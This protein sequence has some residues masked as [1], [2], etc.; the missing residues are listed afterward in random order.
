ME[1]AL[2]K[3]GFSVK[4]IFGGRNW[5]SP[6]GKALD[7]LLFNIELL[8]KQRNGDILYA[9]HIPYILLPILLKRKAYNTIYVHWHGDDLL[10]TTGM[11]RP[12]KKKALSASCGF[13][14]IVPSA[15]FAQKWSELSG[16]PIEEVMI[17]PSG[18]VDTSV[19][20][21]SARSETN[22]LTLGF[23][24][25]L[26]EEKGLIDLEKIIHAKEEL[27]EGSGRK[28]KIRIIDYGKDKERFKRKHSLDYI[29][30]VPPMPK[31]KMVDFYRSIDILLF[32]SQR[33]S[34]S[35]GLV[36][37][38]AM[39]S[40]VPVLGPNRFAVPEYIVPGKSGR[41]YSNDLIG[42]LTALVD[43]MEEL[44]PREIIEERYSLDAVIEM[45]KARFI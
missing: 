34:E 10:K 39:S 35:L 25:G 1:V 22:E 5:T 36:S 19:F 14:H 44:N 8:F 3:A 40:G 17:I 24:S 29:D 6:I 45:Y 20:Y 27:E 16:R 31:E 7:Q 11:W 26:V 12:F 32:F 13:K 33:E 37:L 4:A 41:I 30:Y 23:A 43:E 18:G 42:S 21:P 9:H 28:L 15:Y 2:A 38:E